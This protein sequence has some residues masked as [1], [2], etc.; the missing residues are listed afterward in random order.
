MSKQ[1][2]YYELSDKVVR[3]YAKVPVHLVSGSRID[4]YDHKSTVSWLLMTEAVNYNEDT[5]ERT[6]VYEDEIIELYSQY[7]AD[8]F[9]RLN[10]KLIERGLLKVYTGSGAQVDE[11]NTMSDDELSQILSIRSNE[12]FTTEVN[13]LSSSLTLSRLKQLAVDLGKSV[14]RVQVLESRIKQLN[15]NS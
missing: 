11:T 15:D 8:A 13:K 4:P 1:N 12:D 9:V 2:I 14:K 3:R 6:F 10:K 7:E 5:K